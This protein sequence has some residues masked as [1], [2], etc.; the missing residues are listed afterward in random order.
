MSV[1]VRGFLKKRRDRAVG[2]I[3]GW[4]ERNLQDDLSP[5]QFKGLRDTVLGAVNGMH[6]ATLDL[7]SAE[8]DVV[9]NDHLIEVLEQVE[10][11]LQRSRKNL[12]VHSVS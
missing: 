4:I 12:P 3:M 10:L 2:S 11:E 8:V 7:M 1:P 6:D 9:R 5:E